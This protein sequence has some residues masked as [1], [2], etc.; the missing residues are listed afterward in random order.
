[1]P[2]RRRFVDLASGLVPLV[3]E[4]DIVADT[5]GIRAQLLTDRGQLVDDFVLEWGRSSIHVLN[6]V[7]PGMTCAMP[8]A[9]YVVGQARVR[10]YLN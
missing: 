1:M 3:G 9:E 6:S 7:S 2:P 8:F 4:G 5:A 10:G